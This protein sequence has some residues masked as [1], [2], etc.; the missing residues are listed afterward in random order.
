MYSLVK[1]L[2]APP[3][4]TPVKSSKYLAYLSRVSVIP[5]EPLKYPTIN[6]E[7]G[8]T[9]AWSKNFWNPGSLGVSTW[10]ACASAG[11]SVSKYFAVYLAASLS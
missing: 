8:C 5:A 10:G 9:N 1:S 3:L 6:D 7:A 2:K 4:S 11:V